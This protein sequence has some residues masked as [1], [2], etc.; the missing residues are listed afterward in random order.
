M[1]ELV[2]ERQD[3]PKLLDLFAQWYDK[4]LLELLR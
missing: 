3:I 4:T 2:F 1:A